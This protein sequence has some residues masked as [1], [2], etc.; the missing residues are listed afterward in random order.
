MTSETGSNGRVELDVENGIAALRLTDSEHKNVFSLELGEDLVRFMMAIEER[1]D[2]S[3]V[4]LTAEGDVF[5]A[6]LD[7]SVVRE[8]SSA[9]REFLFDLLR[10]ASDWLYWSEVPV[11]A[12]GVGAMPGAGA[13]LMTAADIRVVGDDAALWWPEIAFGLRAYEPTIQLVS[14]VG[15]PKA[16]EIILLGDRAKVNAEE[17]RRIGLVNRVVAST[18]VDETVRE[19]ATAIARYDDGGELVREHLRVIQHAR[20]ELQGASTAYAKGR[21]LDIDVFNE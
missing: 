3:A 1:D 4:S 6:G 9:E 13:I 20:Q 7:V 2:V 15:A 19:V 11:V 17:A 21:A 18:E 5:C 16:T 8:G 14:T 12:G 10:A